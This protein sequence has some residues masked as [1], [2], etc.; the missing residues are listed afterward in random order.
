MG[1]TKLTERQH[2]E[3]VEYRIS[4]DRIGDAG[5]GYSFPCS[6][7]GILDTSQMSAVGLSNLE[8][9]KTSADF[10]PPTIS[11][12]TNRYTEPATGRCVCGA[13]VCMDGDVKCDCGRW[14]NTFGQELRPPREW[15]EETGERFDDNGN[16]I[17]GGDDGW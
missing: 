11:K 13:V 14:Y 4:F 16:Y 8:Y 17:G 12:Y 9:C 6:S 2:K 10:H 3:H 5:S 15:G 7:T 1:L